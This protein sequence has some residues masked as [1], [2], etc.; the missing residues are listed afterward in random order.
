MREL[1]L[2]IAVKDSGIGR[3]L[4]LVCGVL[5]MALVVAAAAV[6]SSRLVGWECGDVATIHM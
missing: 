5:G 3:R 2:A 6:A 1:R 4:N